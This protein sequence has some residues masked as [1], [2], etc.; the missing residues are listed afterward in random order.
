[1]TEA[2]P[3]TLPIRAYEDELMAR[4][5]ARKSLIKYCEYVQPGYQASKIHHALAEKLEAV[6]RGE[7]KRL[8]VTAPPQHGKS[9]MV[10]VHFP[11][12][13]LGKHPK[14]NVIQTSYGLSLSLKHSRTARDFFISPEFHNVF[15]KARHRPG[16]RGQ[17]LVT[18]IER[19]AAQE[20][21][22]NQGGTYYA[23]GIGGG[24][25]GMGFDIGIID[26]PVKDV[27]EANSELVNERN[28]EWYGSV[29]RTRMSPDAAIILTMTRWS[30]KDLMQKILDQIESGTTEEHWEV[31]HMPAIATADDPHDPTG[32]SEGEALWPE[33]YGIGWLL[34]QKE[35]MRAKPFEALYQGNPTIGEGE[36][37]KRAWWKFYAVAVGAKFPC[38]MEDV[39]QSWDCSFKDLNTSDYV[40]GQVWGRQGTRRYLLDQVRGRMNFL[41]TIN[42]IRSLTGKWPEATRKYIEDKANGTAAIEVLKKEIQGVIAVEPEGGKITR[43]NAVS[44]IIEAGDVF[45]PDPSECLWVH[46]FIEECAAFPNGRNDDQVDT[47]SQALYHMMTIGSTMFPPGIVDQNSRPSPPPYDDT[48]E[49]HGVIGASQNRNAPIAFGI[50]HL[51]TGRVII[52]LLTY[53]NPANGAL[54]WNQIAPAIKMQCRQYRVEDLLH[55]GYEREAMM[56]HFN[57]FLLNELPFTTQH[58]LQVYTTLE[59][60]MY[61]GQIEYPRNDRLISELKSLQAKAPD[62]QFS[63]GPDALANL[64]HHMFTGYINTREGIDDDRNRNWPE[65][66]PGGTPNISIMGGELHT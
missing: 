27:V 2:A 62:G 21:G 43:V 28:W 50:G 61:Q 57:N 65:D 39:V 47:M 63:V 5:E 58:R 25:T 60:R 48:V 36:I 44:G 64:A 8:L 66:D 24:L 14:W 59:N 49:Y 53:F 34:R 46:D 6:E 45:L 23:V 52:D 22:T 7:I 19:Q 4:V 11:A 37:L 40:V 51:H 56:L 31:L 16:R 30:K 18:N 15:P 32:R 26:D 13:C 38:V 29:F 1:M 35:A 42:A 10:S 55:D 33:K 41:T 12:W 20:W 9:R 3:Q 54:D 17:E